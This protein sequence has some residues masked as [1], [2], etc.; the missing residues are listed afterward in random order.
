MS[1]LITNPLPLFAVPPM[2]VRRFS[3]DEYHRMIDVGILTEHDPVEL[4]EGWIVPKMPHNP[5]HDGTIQVINKRVGRRLPDGWDLRVQSAITTDDSEPEPDLAIVRGDERAYIHRHPAP[6]DIGV[7]IEVSSS[8]LTHD[9]QVQGRLYARA[10]IP[11]YWIVN[12]V[13]HCIEVNSDPDRA[14]NPPA[15]RTRTDYRSGDQVPL[16]LDG[17]TVAALPVADL[18]P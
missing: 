5:P 13:D 8:T 11:T 2:P 6:A 9:R 1:L 12:L 4:L 3:V 7:L 14:A 16:V 17:K 15:Y 10:G 18:L